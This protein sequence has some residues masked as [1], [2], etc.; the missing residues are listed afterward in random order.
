RS[1]AIRIRC[2]PPKPPR[3]FTSNSRRGNRS[4]TR[5][6]KISDEDASAV[7]ID[8]AIGAPFDCG[9][10]CIVKSSNGPAAALCGYNKFGGY[11]IAGAPKLYGVIVSGISA[12]QYF[13]TG[14]SGV[15]LS[16]YGF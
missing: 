5:L 14:I 9:L 15:T 16:P 8:G 7:G 3:S 2:Q 4:S 12:T 13:S 10:E 6:P 1:A 11:W